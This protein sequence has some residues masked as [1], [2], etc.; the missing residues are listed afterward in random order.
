MLS[1]NKGAEIEG[2]RSDFEKAKKDEVLN[3][4]DAENKESKS[5]AI[6]SKL[7]SQKKNVVLLVLVCVIVFLIL[8]SINQIQ[9][10][11]L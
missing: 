4:L 1:A 3:K 11:L 6:E 9:M 7:N 8:L 10:I 5:T 2:V